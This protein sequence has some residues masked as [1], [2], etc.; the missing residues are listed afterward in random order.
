[1]AT[2]TAPTALRI[3][4]ADKGRRMTLEQFIEADWEEGWLYELA[5]GVVDVVEVSRPWH[6]RIVDR[7][8][9]MFILYRRQRPGVIQYRAGGGE[10]RLR[11][12][13][14][15]SDRHPDQ[16]IYL[17][18][19]PSGP[20]VWTRWVPHIVVEIV[21]P[22]GEERDFVEK[23]EEYLRIGVREYWILDAVGRRM[24][25]LVRAGDVWEESIV[26]EG[27]VY[28]TNLLPGLEVRPGE[29]LGNDAIG[30]AAE[31]EQ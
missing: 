22:G 26:T 1:M 27:G 17:D 16:A 13:G 2:V 6:G 23:R 18:P 15:V 31:S 24:H 12:P 21:S 3:G 28:Q 20:N 10:C 11:L 14:I 19:E 30:T 29:L 5:R 8:A 4:P 25:S 7:V 9:E